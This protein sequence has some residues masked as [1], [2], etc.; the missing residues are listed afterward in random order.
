MRLTASVLKTLKLPEGVRDCV[1][2]DERLPGFGLRLRA[3][4][5][6]SYLVQYAVAGK[7]RR[8]TIGTPAQLDPGKAFETAKDLLAQVRLGHDP[9]VEKLQ[10]RSRA[11][12]TFGAFLPRFLARQQERLRANS[13]Q[14]AVRYLEAY[15]KPLHTYPIAAVD[16]RMVAALLTKLADK[17]G[18][19]TSN[20]VRSNLSAFF[21]WAAREGLVDVNP[22]AYTNKATENSARERVLADDELKTIWGALEGDTNYGQIV[23]LLLLTGCRHR[24]IS[25]LRWAEIDPVAAQI[26]LPGERV[27]NNKPHIVPLTAPALAILTAQLR[28]PGQDLVFS[29]SVKGFQ[30]SSLPKRALDERIEQREGRRL[31]PWTL[32]DF[33]RTI[34]TWLHE[35]GAS[36]HVVEQLL[37][38]I[39]GH[40][41]GVAGIYN[42]ASY[43]DERRRALNRWADH[44]MA[45]VSGVPTSNV[46]ALR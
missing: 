24:E 4:G 27:K 3:T 21:T 7:T 26:L 45:L 13:Y 12:E 29:K 16:R 14:P 41:A 23:R 36:P 37:N 10:A 9:V 43:L 32:H 20:R 46:V 25:G 18:H 28:E 39:A 40:K 33:R 42:R 19:S 34:S 6:R 44:I 38:H 2:F 17:H 1:F 31:E 5:A 30:N 11:G 15:A 8:M 22:V 35:N